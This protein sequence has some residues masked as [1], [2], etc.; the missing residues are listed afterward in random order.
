MNTAAIQKQNVS[1][2]PLATHF[3]QLGYIVS[4]IEAATA[5]LR[6]SLGVTFTRAEGSAALSDKVLYRGKPHAASALLAF[7]D[8]RGIELEIIQ[9]ITKNN[10]FTEFL[11]AHGSGL[12]HAGFWI[13]DLEQYRMYYDLMVANGHT[14]L[15]Q[16]RLEDPGVEF[17][18]FDCSAFGASVIE[19][20]HFFE[21]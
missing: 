14:Q 8:L 11:D 9:P 19:I 17:C 2:A 16:G 3:S 12:H 7:A 18:Y 1:L 5:A 10:V 4:D 13:P 15:M 20:T 6:K 21:S